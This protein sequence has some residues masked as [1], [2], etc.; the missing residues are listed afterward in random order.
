M[1]LRCGE[2]APLH[3]LRQAYPSLLQK[4]DFVDEKLCVGPDP[5]KEFSDVLW[6]FTTKVLKSKWIS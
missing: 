3:S 4:L 5:F 2:L 6:I 1:I